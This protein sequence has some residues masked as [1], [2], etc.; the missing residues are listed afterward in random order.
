LS[1]APLSGT[2]RAVEKIYTK[3]VIELTN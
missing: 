2:S 3:Y 1:E